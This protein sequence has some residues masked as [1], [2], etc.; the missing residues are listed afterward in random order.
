[1]ISGLAKR[2]KSSRIN[3]GFSRKEAAEMIGITDA[4]VGMYES[5]SRQ[6]SLYALMRLAAVYDVTTDYLLGCESKDKFSLSLAGLTDDQIEV[7]K[8]TV[9]SFRNQSKE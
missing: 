7:V 8:M 2:I 6:P 3:A 9:Q 4:A 5:G 1:M